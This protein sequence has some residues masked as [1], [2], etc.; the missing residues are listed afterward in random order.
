V[1]PKLTAE[2]IARLAK[3]GRRRTVLRGDVLVA[4]AISGIVSCRSTLAVT[5][6]SSA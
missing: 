4:R 5:K 2:Q 6:A 1:F 3:K